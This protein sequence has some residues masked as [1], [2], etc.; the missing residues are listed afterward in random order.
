VNSIFEIDRQTNVVESKQAL[1]K[2]LEVD[3]PEVST[4]TSFEYIFQSCQL[5]IEHVSLDYN[6]Q[7]PFS[8]HDVCF[9]LNQLLL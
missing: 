9:T 6:T 4:L 7:S 8:K 5:V 3:G 2:L 1:G